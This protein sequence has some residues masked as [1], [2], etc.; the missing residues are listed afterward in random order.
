L[1]YSAITSLDGFTA[2]ESGNFETEMTYVESSGL[3]L[4]VENDRSIKDA[5]ART[6]HDHALFQV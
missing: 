1:V 5:R 4:F 2:D 6:E 3:C